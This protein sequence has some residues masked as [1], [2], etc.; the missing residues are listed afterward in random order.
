MNNR[1]YNKD[2]LKSNDPSYCK[3]DTSI[4]WELSIYVSP[5]TIRAHSVTSVTTINVN[6]SDESWY[7]FKNVIRN[8]NPPISIIWMSTIT[9]KIILMDHQFRIRYLIV[10][11]KHNL[12][13]YCNVLGYFSKF[14]F[15]FSSFSRPWSWFGICF[16]F[17]EFS[18]RSRNI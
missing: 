2:V 5:L 6:P 10:K 14:S 11:M 4:V 12:S 17:A 13:C 9:K 3:M 1:P 7:R 16:A 15:S 8:P 18:Y